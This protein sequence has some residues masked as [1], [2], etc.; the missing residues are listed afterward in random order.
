TMAADRMNE[1]VSYLYQPYH[2]AILNLVNNVIE[3]AHAEGKWAGMCGEMAG[4]S[5]AIPILLGLGLDEFSMSA[6]SILPARSQIKNLS[7]EELASYKDQILS[8]STAEEVEAFI[9]KK[10][11]Q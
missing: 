11:N 2:P 10:T 3:A 1:Q 4:D 6:T 7:K 5:I 9:R 8:M